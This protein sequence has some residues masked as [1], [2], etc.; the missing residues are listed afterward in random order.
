MLI[1]RL[2]LEISCIKAFAYSEYIRRMFYN[3]KKKKFVKREGLNYQT[4]GYVLH[5]KKER[6]DESKH[7]RKVA[8]I[9]LL[10][11]LPTI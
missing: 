1:K 6:E 3:W 5:P 11:W 4:F 8:N 2:I 9:I 7:K 10:L